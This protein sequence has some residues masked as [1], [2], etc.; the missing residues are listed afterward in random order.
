M[1][2]RIIQRMKKQRLPL[3]LA[4]GLPVVLSACS[5]LPAAE[6]V[7]SWTLRPA[8]TENAG[9]VTVTDLQ[10]LRAQA[11][12]L[13]SGRYL[14][15]VPEAQPISVYSGQRWSA[16]IP[17]LWR[18]Y[19]VSALQ[20]DSRF[21]RISSDAVRID[22]RYELVSRIDAFQSEYRD[23]QPVAVM[24]GY[25]QLIDSHSR[26]II[27]ERTLELSQPAE[28]VEVAAVV[29][30]FSLLMAQASHEIRDWLLRVSP[31]RS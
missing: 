3:G 15:V 19:L 18:D 4:L 29:D 25:L 22:A 2:R 9:P 8:T 16:S 24:R 30:A 28:G 5:L 26:A 11:Q 17:T 6:P 1:L 23:G 12:D 20:R 13:L 7:Q 31:G 10:V 27:A 21:A 14:L